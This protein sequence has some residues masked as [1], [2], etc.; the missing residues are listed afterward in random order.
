MDEYA[1]YLAGFGIIIAIIVLFFVVFNVRL[2]GDFL[3]SCTGKFYEGNK[4]EEFKFDTFMSLRNRDYVIDLNGDRISLNKF[5]S[6]N[7][8]RNNGE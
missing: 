7:C 3:Q 5:V 6:V 1:E 2:E 8:Q 4:W